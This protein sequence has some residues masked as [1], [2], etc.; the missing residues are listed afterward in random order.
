M[1]IFSE[2]V[3]DLRKSYVSFKKSEKIIEN[4]NWDNLQAEI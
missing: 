3:G 4:L 2:R 1:P